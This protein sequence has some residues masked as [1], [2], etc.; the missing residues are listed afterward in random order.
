LESAR[1]A[2][3]VSVSYAACV[4]ASVHKIDRV[5]PQPNG[6]AI[7][8]V[9]DE[10]SA[11][12]MALV[13]SVSTVIAV[14]RILN[15]RRM[16]ETRYGGKG[17]IRYATNATPPTFLAEAIARAGAGLSDA[18]GEQVKVPAA[19]ASVSAVID[20]AFAELAHQ[21]RTNANATDMIAALRTTEGR[22]RKSPLDKDANPAAYWT[23]VFELAAL[24][25]E[26]SRPRGGRWIETKDMPV[27]FAIKFAEGGLA[28][29]SKL[30]Q[31]IVEGGDPEQSMATDVT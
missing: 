29:P 15:A 25:G 8:L 13:P 20:Q 28:M 7:V 14:A 21:L 5:R 24:A 4:W 1:P 30:A 12:K 17:E 3:L 10:R 26:M 27:P 9:E 31:I 2:F 23:A 18:S 11:A 22:R 6:G 16:L 19:P